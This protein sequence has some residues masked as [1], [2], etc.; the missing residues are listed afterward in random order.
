MRD[1][2]RGGVVGVPHD[3]SA[4]VKPVSSAGTEGAVVARIGLCGVGG[5]DQHEH[6][7]SALRHVMQRLRRQAL[8]PGGEAPV[9]IPAEFRTGD[10]VRWN[11]SCGR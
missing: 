11:A 10:V 8:G 9:S 2:D 3:P 1:V 7:T 5:I 4:E 6:R